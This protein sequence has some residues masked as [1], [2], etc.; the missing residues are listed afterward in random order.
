MPV[1][2]IRIERGTHAVNVR[3]QWSS[4]FT[5][6]FLTLG[7]GIFFLLL[8]NAVGLNA[9]NTARADITSALRFW[10]WLYVAATWV[11]SFFLGGLLSTRSSE[12]NTP[13]SGM[14]HALTSWGLATAILGVGGAI[15]AIGFRA[16]LIGLAGDSANWLSACIIGL[17]GFASAIGGMLGKFSLQ[18]HYRMEAEP[19]APTTTERRVA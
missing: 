15:A 18:D 16:L 3:M 9:V 19:A 4:I 7:F 1:R 10:S 8:G 6:A 11:L 12:L 13:S 17:G 2:L 5:G 14:I